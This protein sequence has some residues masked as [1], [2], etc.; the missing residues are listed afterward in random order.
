MDCCPLGGRGGPV[1]ETTSASPNT[2]A[3]RDDAMRADADLRDLWRFYARRVPDTWLAL[4][5]SV[6]ILLIVGFAVVGLTHAR[7][8]LRWWPTALLPMLAGAFGA[9][10]I[11]DRELADRRRDSDSRPLAVRMLI[12]IE[13]ASCVAAALAVAA[14]MIVF[15]RV[16][17][18]T[19]IS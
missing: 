5:V 7:W 4:L 15:L 3:P 1:N 19:W 12:G 6:S 13:W 9:W 14:A 10:G 11:A 2:P 8:A 18:G 17:V 16:T